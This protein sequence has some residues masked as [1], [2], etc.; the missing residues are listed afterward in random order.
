MEYMR[1]AAELKK[2]LH[3][4]EPTTSSGS[5]LSSVSSERSPNQVLHAR[6]SVESDQFQELLQLS[7]MTPKLTT[8]LEIA[9]AAEEY[10]LEAQYVVAL[11]KYQVGILICFANVEE[12]N[13]YQSTNPI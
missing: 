8:G 7:R 9:R 1:R 2:A 11:E 3:P 6:T 10:E 4:E 13:Y 5:P 12:Y